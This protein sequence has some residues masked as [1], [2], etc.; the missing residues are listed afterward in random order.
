MEKHILLIDD[1]VDEPE[2]FINALE[3][4]K[5]SFHCTWAPGGSEAMK[6]L[7]TTKPDFI[8]LDFNMPKMNGLE[9]LSML[10]AHPGMQHIPVIMY[11]ATMDGE[12]SDKALKKG[13]VRCIRKPY[14]MQQLP[15]LLK[16]F[17]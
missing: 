2:I 6:H 16:D 5:A 11:S 17:L 9:V 1:D 13:A 3:E 4:A 8:L 14:D 7:E 10:K 15:H 12:L